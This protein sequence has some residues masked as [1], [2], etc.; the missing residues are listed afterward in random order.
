MA[1]NAMAS[2]Q[3]Q[4]G[5]VLISVLVLLLLVG[6]AGGANYYRNWQSEQDEQGDRPFEG[7][8]I[9]HLDQLATAYRA[10]LATWEGRYTKARQ[11]R[12]TA[13]Q[14]GTMSGN[15]KQFDKAVQASVRLRKL[16][17]EVAGRE[18]RLREIEDEQ[19]YRTA[20]EGIDLHIRRL[21]RI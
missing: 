10:E 9:E 20:S 4:S 19:A 3:G 8:T 6:G 1:K 12:F 11:Q 15:V 13:K 2:S 17:S 14:T 7:Y 16:N 21:T 18:A 5:R